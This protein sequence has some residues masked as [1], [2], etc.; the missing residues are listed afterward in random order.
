V[1]PYI[2]GDY[3]TWAEDNLAIIV[4]I[5][6][7]QAVENAEAILAVE[8]VLGCFIGPNDLARSMGISPNDTGP[9]TEHEAAMMEVLAVAQKM[10]KAAGKHCHSSAEVSLRIAQGFQFLALSSDVG[11]LRNAAREALKGIDFA[12]TEQPEETK[13]GKSALY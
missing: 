11:L 12:E 10:G 8:G 2:D 3:Y 5:E 4:M 9:G 7:A 13:V 1:A 6:T